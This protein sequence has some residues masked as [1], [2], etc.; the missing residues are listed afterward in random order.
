MPR[1][2]RAGQ[3]RRR[4]FDRC[5]AAIAASGRAVGVCPGPAA[6]GATAGSGAAGCRLR[7]RITKMT[8]ATM[9]TA[10]AT[11]TFSRWPK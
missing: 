7:K 11:H 2:P 9:H 6:A 5:L 4:R 3:P 1:A 8:A 10:D